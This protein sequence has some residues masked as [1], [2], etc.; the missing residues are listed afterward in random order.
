MGGFVAFQD[1]ALALSGPLGGMLAQ[2]MELGSV[3]LV[4]AARVASAVAV[5]VAVRWRCGGGAVRCG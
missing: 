5:A 3:F 2:A 1:I 4:G